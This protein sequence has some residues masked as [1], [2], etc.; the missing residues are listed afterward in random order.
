MIDIEKLRSSKLISTPFKY[1]KIES[2]LSVIH[3]EKLLETL[4]LEGN[5][6]SLRKN[7]SDKIYNVVN[8]ILVEL[9]QTTLVNPN[10]SIDWNNLIIELQ[11]KQYREALSSLLDEDLV[12]CYMEIT[13][14]RYKLYD[15]IS[16]HTDK[17]S[18][19]ATHM[20]FLNENWE[21]DWGGMLYFLNDAQEILEVFLPTIAQSVAFVRSDIS[22]HK[23]CPVL[24]VEKERVVIQVAFWNEIDRTIAPGRIIEEI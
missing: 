3:A 11:G 19:R 17:P 24:A 15:Y 5:Y 16:A 12:N 2:I 9:G 22:W 18:V 6:R 20:I 13:L 1:T 21:Q 23:V 7:G 10:I 8:N 14:K 4:P